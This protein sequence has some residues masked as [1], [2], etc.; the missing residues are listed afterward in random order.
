VAA[1]YQH[2]LR[3]RQVR[4]I[5]MGGAIGT[6]L[7]LGAGSRLHSAAR[8][9]PSSTRSPALSRSSWSAAVFVSRPRTIPA[10]VPGAD[11]NSAD[12]DTVR[13]VSILGGGEGSIR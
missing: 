11:P 7:F 9:R 13:N 2:S 4:M 5:A 12:G 8:R 6:G 10:G 3:N 1:G